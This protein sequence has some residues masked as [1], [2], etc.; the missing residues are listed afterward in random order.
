[1]T[2]P[3]FNRKTQEGKALDGWNKASSGTWGVVMFRQGCLNYGATE[4]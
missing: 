1:M 2:D 4:A 3:R